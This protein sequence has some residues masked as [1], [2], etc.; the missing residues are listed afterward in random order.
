M[1]CGH[2]SLNGD[3]LPSWPCSRCSCRWPL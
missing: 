2:G 3:L 1:L